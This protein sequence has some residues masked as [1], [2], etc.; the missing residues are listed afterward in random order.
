[1]Q[2]RFFFLRGITSQE[3][4]SLFRMTRLE[5]IHARYEELVIA[6]C[7][8]KRMSA[9]IDY[10]FS[11]PILTV[12]QLETALDMP[13]MAAKRYVDKLV[14]AGVLKETTG[15]ARNRV[16]VAHEVFRALQNPE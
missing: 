7:N 16:C 3:Q 10:M 14:E 12:R 15:Y 8:P 9:V 2:A 4:D 11:R 5:G 1:V 13:Y 6:D